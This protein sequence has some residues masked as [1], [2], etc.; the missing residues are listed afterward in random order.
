[1]KRGAGCQVLDISCQ[2]P[3]WQESSRL[4]DPPA[5]LVDSNAV[6]HTGL[7]TKN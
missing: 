3:W 1:M 4:S 2:T 7:T 5:E 6:W